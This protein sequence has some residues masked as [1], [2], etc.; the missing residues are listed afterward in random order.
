[1]FD[2][3]RCGATQQSGGG[4]G[5][6]CG[7]RNFFCIA[8][9]L[10]SSFSGF[11]VNAPTVALSDPKWIPGEH[12]PT[13]PITDLTGLRFTASGKTLKWR[14][15]LQEGFEFHVEVPAGENEVTANFD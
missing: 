10:S 9:F 2:L 8:V 5:S 14:R 4:M 11:G 13:G 7:V 15:D 12:G 6:S 3:G 1:M